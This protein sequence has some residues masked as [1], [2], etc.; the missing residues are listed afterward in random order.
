MI[1]LPEWAMS[2][3]KEPDWWARVPAWGG[4]VLAASNW[5]RGRTTLRLIL[6]DD[7]KVANT[8]PHAVEIEHIGLVEGDGRLSEAWAAEPMTYP[9]LPCKIEPRSS[10]SFSLGIANMLTISMEQ[11]QHGRYGCYVRLAGGYLFS[12]PGRVGRAWW[13]LSSHFRKETRQGRD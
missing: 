3:L 8:S 12:N 4:L 5:W 9:Q 7:L 13:R 6:D 11:H 10:M 2:F 1:F